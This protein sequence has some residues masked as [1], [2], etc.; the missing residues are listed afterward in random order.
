MKIEALSKHIEQ[1]QSE[2]Q[3]VCNQLQALSEEKL[4]LEGHLTCL[5]GLHN[6]LIDEQRKGKQKAPKN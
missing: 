2:Y 5:V 4:R 1:K 3:S 6:Q